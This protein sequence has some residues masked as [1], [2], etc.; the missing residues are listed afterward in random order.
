MENGQRYFSFI[1]RMWLA[2]DTDQPQWHA[3]LE[4]TRTGERRGFANL[5]ALCEYLNQQAGQQC[6]Q[7]N[8]SKE[9][10]KS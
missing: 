1:L 10:R 4:D 9:G 2:G 3:S 8:Q 5:A 7:E 6:E